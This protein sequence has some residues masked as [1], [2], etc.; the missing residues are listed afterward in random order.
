MIVKKKTKLNTEINCI[1]TSWTYEKSDSWPAFLVDLKLIIKH[2]V[3]CEQQ[4]KHMNTV[5][6]KHVNV[7]LLFH[8]FQHDVNTA[9]GYWQPAESTRKCTSSAK[10]MKCTI[11]IET[12]VI[13]SQPQIFKDK[14]LHCVFAC[15]QEVCVPV[16]STVKTFVNRGGV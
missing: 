7:I 8:L 1:H 14:Y 6:V 15:T 2:N 5:Q 4:V 12:W 11:I 3:A 16:S 9:Q 10:N 13:I